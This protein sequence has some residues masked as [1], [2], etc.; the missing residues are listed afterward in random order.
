MLCGFRGM[1]A[2][3]AENISKTNLQISLGTMQQY[4]FEYGTCERRTNIHLSPGTFRVSQQASLHSKIKRIKNTNTNSHFVSIK[5]TLFAGKMYRNFRCQSP[6]TFFKQK[7]SDTTEI[8]H[9]CIAH[10]ALVFYETCGKRYTT[11]FCS[12]K[13]LQS[14]LH[15]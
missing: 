4:V 7:S 8:P 6:Y 5:Y 3:A 11:Y 14:L 13:T 12:I 9:I 15:L 2:S 1:Y 10:V